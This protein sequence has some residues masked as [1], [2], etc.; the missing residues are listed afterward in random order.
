MIS[1]Q[2]LLLS[3]IVL[4]DIYIYIYIYIYR[5]QPHLYQQHFSYQ[6]ACATRQII[7]S[8]TKQTPQCI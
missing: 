6:Y 2:S 3:T 7:L 4:N 8:I 5:F 1:D